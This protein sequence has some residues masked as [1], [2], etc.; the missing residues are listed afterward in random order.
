MNTIAKKKE[1]IIVSQLKEGKVLALVTDAGMPG[2]S[3]PG[4]DLVQACLREGIPFEV[5]PG[6]SAM[7]TALVASGLSTE[8]FAF[9]GFLPRDKKQRKQLLEKHA[10]IHEP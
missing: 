4:T 10:R 1:P 9:E 6:P 7:L 3:D 8:R 2:I 5:L